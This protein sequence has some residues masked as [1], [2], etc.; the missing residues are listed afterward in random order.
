MQLLAL[1][2]QNVKSRSLTKIA[3]HKIKPPSGGF[4]VINVLR[5]RFFLFC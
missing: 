4:F 5:F 2:Q 3:A 1:T